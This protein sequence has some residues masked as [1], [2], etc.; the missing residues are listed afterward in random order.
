MPNNFE[1]KEAFYTV[2]LIP[3]NIG[4]LTKTLGL[5]ASWPHQFVIISLELYAH[6]LF[7]LF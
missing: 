5:V 7:D 3:T 6:C 1:L 4:I 2:T